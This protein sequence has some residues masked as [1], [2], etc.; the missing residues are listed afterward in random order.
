M[1]KSIIV[2][3]GLL[4]GLCL[5]QTPKPRRWR[6]AAAYKLIEL[7]LRPY[8]INS[9]GMVAGTVNGKAALWSSRD[10]LREL[11]AVDGYPLVEITGIND[12]GAVIGTVSRLTHSETKA[13]LYRDGKVTIIPD[14]AKPYAINNAGVIAGAAPLAGK[15][16][17][18]AVFWDNGKL[19]DLG[20]CCGGVATSLNQPGDAV[21]NAYDRDARYHA[22]LWRRDGGLQWIGSPQSFS[23]AIAIN[24]KGA[25]LVQRFTEGIFLF[26]QGQWT[27]LELSRKANDVRALNNFNLVV[28]AFGPQDGA[29]LLRR[30][31][32][33]RSRFRKAAQQRRHFGRQAHG[34]IF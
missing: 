7:P 9:A 8:C 12:S 21:G 13:F 3:A 15:P 26:Q 34:S 4:C 22:F 23:S 29:F 20:N 2:I 10:G 11:P 25:V 27:R 32:F 6:S 30:S 24:D 1:N 5:G 31:D 33:S 16:G 17:N 18:S 28:G 14:L 19:V